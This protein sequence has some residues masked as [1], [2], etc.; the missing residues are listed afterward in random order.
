MSSAGAI[1][2]RPP[3][4]DTGDAR[5][6]APADAAPRDKRRPTAGAF[7][8]LAILALAHT[9]LPWALAWLGQHGGIQTVELAALGLHLFGP[10]IYLPI[11]RRVQL[12]WMR[13][14][15]VL[16]INHVFVLLGAL[17][18]LLR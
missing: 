3:D 10:L 5:D 1:S 15:L 11:Y 4:G 9:P 13:W 14:A 8:L 7:A 18:Y 6:A 17:P 2:A 16:G 12:S